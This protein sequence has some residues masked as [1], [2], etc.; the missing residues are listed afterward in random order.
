VRLLEA[1][2]SRTTASARQ[3]IE[4]LTDREEEVLRTVARGRTNAEIAEEL[5]ISLS[6]VK[7]HL[8]SLMQK[9]GA[10]NRVEVA[11]W[12]YETGRMSH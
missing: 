6:T 8:A 1:F 12:A 2:A 9:L 3:P 5:Y 7:T 11:M 4:P 10:R